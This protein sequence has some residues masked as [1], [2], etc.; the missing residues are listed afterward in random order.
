MSPARTSEFIIEVN[1]YLNIPPIPNERPGGMQRL[2]FGASALILEHH[3]SFCSD[4]VAKVALH[5]ICSQFALI[6][7]I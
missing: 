6:K 4:I 5:S 2:C 1:S 3:T 7:L